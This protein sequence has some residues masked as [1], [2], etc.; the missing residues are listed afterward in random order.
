[1]MSSTSYDNNLCYSALPDWHGT[2]FGTGIYDDLF[3]DG[4]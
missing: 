2:K 3:I 4:N 1:M